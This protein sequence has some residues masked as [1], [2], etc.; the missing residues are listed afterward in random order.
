MDRFVRICLEL[1]LLDLQYWDNFFMVAN[2]LVGV[3]QPEQNTTTVGTQWWFAGGSSMETARFGDSGDLAVVVLAGTRVV[4]GGSAKLRVRGKKRGRAE[5]YGD[6]SICLVGGFDR[7]SGEGDVA[8]VRMKGVRQ[9]L[10]VSDQRR[11][12]KGRVVRM[13]SSEFADRSKTQLLL[14]RNGGSSM[15]MARLGDSGGSS[16]EMAS[17]GDSGDLVVVVLSGTRVAGRGSAK[18]QVSGKKRER[19]EGDGD[20]SVCL[21]EGFGQSSGEGDVTTMRV[22]GLRQLLV[23]SD[24]KRGT[25]GRCV[26]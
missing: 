21:V 13:N 19:E 16:M 22:K 10:V 17:L 5:G 23:I 3:C 26:R 4:G 18:L 20:G 15:E 6:G 2:E 12:K 24:R 14:A 11:G 1:N 7:S 9:L 25:K 8:T